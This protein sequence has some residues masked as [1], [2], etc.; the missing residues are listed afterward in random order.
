MHGR[1][2]QHRE[3]HQQARAV[4]VA[5]GRAGNYPG[6]QATNIIPYKLVE[7]A[8]ENDTGTE[9]NQPQPNKAMAQIGV[10]APQKVRACAIA[11]QQAAEQ[12]RQ[13]QCRRQRLPVGG[14]H[15]KR[16]EAHQHAPQQRQ[17]AQ[18]LHF[19]RVANQQFLALRFADEPFGDP[20]GSFSFEKFAGQSGGVLDE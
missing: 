5:Q 2:N 13:A 1:P 6:Q 16:A 14:H 7:L 17:Q 9:Q 15:A 20:G 18:G 8:N 10:A 3:Q 12:Q 11:A 19:G 4:H